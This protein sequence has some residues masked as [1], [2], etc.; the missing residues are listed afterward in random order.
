MSAAAIVVAGSFALVA[1][2]LAFLAFNIPGSGEPAVVV[3][4]AAGLKVPVEA[5]ARAYEREFGVAVRMNFSG[6]GALLA[7]LEIGKQGDLFL[8]ADDSY[9]DLA[10]DKGLVGE[11]IP[12]A[13]QT[14]V[15]A[16]RRDNPGNLRS[17]AD[18]IRGRAAIA[19]ANP[20]TAAIGKMTRDAL[21]KAGLWTAFAEHIKVY[22]P[23][24]NEVANDLK[25]GAVDAGIIWDTLLPQYPELM[26]VPDEV[27]SRTRAHVAVGVLDWSTQMDEARR[28]ARYLCAPNRGMIEWQRHGYGPPREN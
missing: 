11:R 20:E 16:V 12:V 3:H 7:G 19:H 5:V 18:V 10:R 13:S 9:L 22:K 2:L 28:F 21:E 23:T 27:L 24:V 17:L 26:E 1:I 14:A 25:L 6:S 15:L 8:P 4:C